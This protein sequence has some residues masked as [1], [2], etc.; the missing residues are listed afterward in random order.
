M[1]TLWT[2]GDSFTYCSGYNISTELHLLPKEI[3][4]KLNNIPYRDQ[5]DIVLTY[6]PNLS[7]YRETLSIDG[8]LLWPE[9]V[10]QSTGVGRLENLGS[11]GL[12]NLGIIDVFTT[13]ISKFKKGDIVIV[14][15]TRGDRLD[16]PV[17]GFDKGGSRVM[18]C[19]GLD[20]AFEYKDSEATKAHC[21]FKEFTQEQYNALVDYRYS[22]LTRD[23]GYDLEY[24]YRDI[25]K[26]IGR[27]L[28]E[29]GISFWTW[30][31]SLWTEFESI[32]G[33]TNRRVRDGHWSHN[34]FRDFAKF[35]LDSAGS[36]IFNLDSKEYRKYLSK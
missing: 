25:L 30:D 36:G 33:F 6:L 26:N 15:T 35:V 5:I 28:V 23:R 8:V 18:P 12:S 16:V 31:S 13:H 10:A 27:Y 29:K 32:D 7:L 22:I 34:G 19:S 17:G 21:D 9:I 1:K 2:F 14:G 20:V 3:K 24:R 4:E 11:P